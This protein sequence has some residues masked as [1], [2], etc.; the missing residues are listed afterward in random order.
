[1]QRRQICLLFGL[2]RSG[3]TELIN[4]QGTTSFR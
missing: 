1:L 2:Q 3:R 4:D